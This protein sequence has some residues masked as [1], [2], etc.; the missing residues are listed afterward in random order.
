M[1]VDTSVSAERWLLLSGAYH[2]ALSRVLQQHVPI[3]GYC[4]DAGANLGFFTIQFAHWV[5]PSGRVAAFEPNPA[6]VERVRQNV[7]I[8]GF[9][10]V[11]IVP[12]AIHD[13]PGII[14]FYIDKDP[15]KSSL[16]ST[17]V[18]RPSEVIT[19]EAL[20]L[21]DYLAE[22]RWPRLDAIKMDIEG[23][24]CRALLAAESA[25]VHFHP[26]IAFEYKYS[27]DPALA[28][29]V[30]DMFARLGY[31]LEALG[32]DG[33][34]FAFDWRQAPPGYKQVD[35]LCFHNPSIPLS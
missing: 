31:R 35:V 14:Q 23:N 30:F 19:A 32:F 4:I 6:M 25:L 26:F 7:N 10:H 12:K 15:A 34:R 20:P 11:D 21:A 1:H 22:A 33:R 9:T 27:T 17:A 3:G 28:S 16:D 29:Q 18:R 8:N 13:Q 2:P 24:D 5:G